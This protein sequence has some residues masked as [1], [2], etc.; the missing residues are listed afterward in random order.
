M[1]L[2]TRKRGWKMSNFKLFIKSMKAMGD[3]LFIY[4]FSILGMSICT[5]MFSI[6]G[7]LLMKSVVDIA[8]TGRYEIL[9]YTIAVIVLVG[10]I[11]LVIYRYAAIIYNVEAKRVH[12]VLSQ[13]VLEVEMKLPYSYY[14][15]HHSGE[16]ISKVSYDLT[17]M[18]NIYGSRFRRVIMPFLEVIVFLVPMFYLSWQLT[19]CLVAVNIVILGIDI[20]LA[21]PMRKVS[22]TLSRS[23]S[24]MT[25][26]LSDLLQGMEQVRMYRAGKDILENFQKENK[27]YAK[28]YGRK[29]FLSACLESADRGFDLLCSLF[30]LMIGIYFVKQGYTT[31]GALAAI[32]TM[33]GSFSFQFLMMGKYIPELVGC[34]AN[35]KN[36][37]DFL[38][39]E[40]EPGNW[41]TSEGKLIVNQEL[42]EHELQEQ[43]M[44]EQEL[45]EQKLS[46]QELKD[47]E[48]GNH[49]THRQQTETALKIENITFSYVEDSEVL[50]NFSISVKKGECVA[51]TGPSGC[52]KTTLSKLLLGLYPIPDG[53]IEINGKEMRK[54]SLAEMRRQIAYVPQESYLFQGSI[55]DNIMLGRPGAAEQEMIEAAKLANAH[56]FIMSFPDGYETQVS[57]RGNNMS[58]GQRQ[59]IAIARAILKD[60]PVILLDE[61][62]SALDNESEQMVN[63]AMKNLQGNRTILMIA[64]RPCTIQLA[65]WVYKM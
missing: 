16:I 31:L 52:G 32:Y 27:E 49:Q 46:Y 12:G 64:H 6:M 1:H 50:D 21:E 8:Q 25:S 18:C 24:I 19:L 23:N 20:F 54:H 51:I 35:A 5:A 48:S 2:C 45:Q 39:E 14:E 26:R 58:G 41:Y 56:D 36:I 33:Y 38:D 28:K 62:T 47:Q 10:V 11:S 43:E 57:E 63:D 44:Q 13:K 40:R 17:G 61:A 7:S 65:D 29:T 4:L 53:K 34:L 22:Q 59:R 60:A 30:F 42:Q 9:G 37:F 3:R 15:T 55:R